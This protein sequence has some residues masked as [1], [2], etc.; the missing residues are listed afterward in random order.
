[1]CSR[2]AA[3][4]AAASVPVRI[5]AAGA[6]AAPDP[7]VR[8]FTFADRFQDTLCHLASTVQAAG[9][10]LNVLGLRDGGASFRLPW[11]E[12]ESP[13]ENEL[14]HF[15]DRSIM[16][17]KHLFLARAIRRLPANATIVFVDGFDVLFQRPLTDLVRSYRALARARGMGS[18]GAWP[19][20]FSG[21]LN[22]WPFPHE[23]AFHLASGT[24]RIPSYAMLSSDYNGARHFPYGDS[25]PWSIRGD[26]VCREWL[27]QRDRGDLGAR[28]D[29]HPDLRFPF[30]CAGAFMGT[31]AALRRLYA[32]LFSLYRA[33]REYHDQALLILLLLRNHSLGFVDEAASLFLSLH[34]HD[35][36]RDLPR[37]LC[38]DGYFASASEGLAEEDAQGAKEPRRL[39]G[40]PPPAPRGAASVY[41]DLGGPPGLLHFNGNAKQHLPRC[42]EY[43]RASGFIHDRCTYFDSDRHEYAG[44]RLSG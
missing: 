12:L 13:R 37:R 11:G 19:V 23:Q 2:L 41:D 8:V 30:L 6:G 39:G 24:H 21:E 29:E 42:V 25:S 34:G 44:V 38:Y 36:M 28:P 33:T 5:G 16:L 20:V 43:F 3:C 4:V 22:C 32:R 31:A 40:R 18:G 27:L 26:A 1:M 17:K 14:W 7:G 10:V 15:A 35:E 9:G